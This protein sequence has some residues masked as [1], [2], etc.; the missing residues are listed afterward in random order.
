MEKNKK[1]YH[2]YA[3]TSLIFSLLFWIPLLNL[4]T[5]ILA[6]IFG[7]IAIKEIKTDKQSRGTGFAIFAI[8]MGIFTIAVSILG[9]VLYP[10]YYLGQNGTFF[11]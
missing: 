8:T 1:P 3:I 11:N 2:S 4:F 5:S 10:E 9:F 7:F 6:I